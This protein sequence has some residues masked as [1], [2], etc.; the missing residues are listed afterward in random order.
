ME[1]IIQLRFTERNRE[2]IKKLTAIKNEMAARGLLRSGNTVTQGHDALVN[3]FV[4]SK[5]IIVNTFSEYLSLTK[6][7]K[8]DEKLIDIAFKILDERKLSLENLYK[9]QM[10]PIFSTLSN[11]KMP[12]SY[13]TLDEKLA[14]NK[15]ELEIEL[16]K[17]SDLYINSKGKTLYERVKNQ[18]LDRPIIVIII[19]VIT[20]VTTILTFL[21][22][23][24]TI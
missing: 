2:F 15:K 8:A 20:A 11:K 12:E 21:K 3:E 24:G 23:I 10:K 18:F 5:T 13:F 9:E 7:N 19:I 1:E 16:A 6:P 14:L 17:A 4:E 22:L